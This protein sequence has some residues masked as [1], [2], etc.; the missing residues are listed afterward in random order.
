MSQ[1]EVVGK[2]ES[3]F[4]KRIF[5]IKWSWVVLAL[6]LLLGFYFRAYHIDY[7]VIGYHNWKEVHHLSEARNYV[8]DG[9]SKD[10]LFMPHYDDNTF[11]ENP[12]GLHSD[13][14]PLVQIMGAVIFRIFG[15]KLWMARMISIIFNLGAV[16]MFYLLIKQLFKK[17]DKKEE[18]SLTCAFLAAI[19]PLLVFFSHNFDDINPALFFML[20]CAFLYAKWVDEQ[21]GWQLALAALFGGF[22]T[23]LKYTF[24]IIAVPILITFPYKKVFSALKKYWK[25]LAVSA[26]MILVCLSWIPYASYMNKIHQGMSYSA[27]EIVK[28]KV[29]WG[30]IPLLFSQDFLV[31]VLLSPNSYVAD[32]YSKIGF[33][34]AALG[35]VLLLIFWKKGFGNKFMSAYFIAFILFIVVGSDTLRGHSYH[36]YPI[37][38]LIIFLMAYLFTFVG[39]TLEKFFNVKFLSWFVIIIFIALLMKPSVDAKNRQFNTQFIGQD[40]AG[41]YIKKHMLP[42][43]RML[44]PSH[45]SY[46]VI[47]NS[48]MKAYMFPENASIIPLM[49]EEANVS[50]VFVYQWGFSI[51]DNKPVWDYIKEHYSLAQFGFQQN[52]GLIYILLKKGGSFNASN[53]EEVSNQLNAI[54]QKSLASSIKSK[55]YEYTTGKFTMNYYDVIA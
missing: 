43:E 22:A 10:G 23:V 54:L 53:M 7:P 52:T 38:P 47:W 14:F 20:G 8:L 33:T 42:G 9:F 13:T 45:Q 5:N 46:G 49:E 21:K 32:N 40:V 11:G 36:Q 26:L 37:A 18:L 39:T 29:T 19:N 15:Y 41:D 48:G 30:N 6:I 24:G 50:W 55:E 12:Y 3:I 28:M 17:Y 2:E 16:L 31:P 1:K 4:S 34:F 27:V 44:F 25:S 35:F 51:L